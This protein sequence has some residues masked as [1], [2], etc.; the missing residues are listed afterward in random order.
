MDVSGKRIPTECCNITKRRRFF[1][2]LLFSFL[3][4]SLAKAKSRNRALH[5]KQI[6]K[7]S[8]TEKS[9]QI[10]DFLFVLVFLKI[11][12]IGDDDR[13][14]NSGFFKTFSLSRILI[15]ERIFERVRKCS[16]A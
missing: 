12:R 15:D 16:D 14:L 11:Q 13:I 7:Q 9:F 4:L 8:N 2:P 10:W 3:F 1:V 5:Q 6:K